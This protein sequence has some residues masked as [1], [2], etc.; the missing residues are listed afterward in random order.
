[1]NSVKAGIVISG[2]IDGTT[3]VYDVVAVQADGTP[4][5]LTQFYDE[6]KV[7]PDWE[8]IY[9]SGVSAD[10]AT[11]PRVLI[12]AFDTSSGTDI[13]TTV[14]SL[15]VYYNDT[16]VT[17]DS[18]TGISTGS[19]AG[20]LKL[21]T[22]SY[23]GTDVPC[24]MFIGNPADAST[25][26]DDDRIT[27][28]GTVVSGGGQISFS[29]IGKD[30]QIR[31][32]VDANVG[33]TAELHVPLT[34]PKY[35]M[36][37]SNNVIVSTQRIAKLYYN[38]SAVSAA[39]MTGYT[40]K[41]YDITGPTEVELTGTSTDI[42]ISQTL[43]SGDTITVGP[44]AVDCLLTM[45]CRIFDANNQELASAT[46]A[47][48]D[49]S[50]P[51]SVMWVVSDD[52]TGETNHAEYTGFE[53]RVNIRS[54]QTKYFIPKVV[55]DKGTLTS[56]IT[57]TFNADNANTGDTISDLPGVPSTSGQTY[58]YIRYAD[59]VQTDTNGNKVIRPVKLHAQSSEI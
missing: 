7:V 57:W 56:T 1:M 38:G 44:D 8:A 42:T 29:G 19:L 16:L 30:V 31:S 58:C 25:N 45:R 34:S 3:V 55:T 4:A 36:T 2:T 35:I 9:E 14:S 37:N 22:F 53:P 33:Y 15:S 48:Y 32:I 39:D 5:S 10:I 18:T 40:F 12:R 46:T 28:N 23:S 50:D 6:A 11:L 43:V 20:L 26:P 47:I 51:Y 49:L 24:V 27:F 54:G 52:S 41:F 13:T 21:T 59:V 17:F